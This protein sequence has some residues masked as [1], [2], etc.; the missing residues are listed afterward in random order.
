MIPCAE[1]KTLFLDVGGTLISID[2]DW[3][4][5]EINARG[6]V[7]D[8]DAVCRAEAAA[9][10][11]ISHRLH[12]P[13]RGPESARFYT[14]LQ[15]I[16]ARLQPVVGAGPQ[17]VEALA[18]ELSGVLCP[19][20][21]ANRLWSSVMPG[22][23]EALEA[24]RGRGLQLVAVSN[25]DGSAEQSLQE[26]GLRAYFSVVIDSAR[27][28]F[29]KP[30]PRIFELALRVSGAE[31]SRTLH[32]GDM[33]HADVVGARGAGISALLLDPFDDWVG[34]DCERLPDLDAL[35]RQQGGRKGSD[36][37]CAPVVRFGGSS[38][39]DS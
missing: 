17:C 14:Y 20:G 28:G 7:C 35:V 9:K 16:F 22:V 18:R 27:V 21:Q 23:P 8:T 38:E 10:P 4:A 34:V 33:Y 24:F 37:T 1:L 15:A 36:R 26:T 29:A 25:S 6:F 11:E 31:R 3:V 13:E 32:V 5:A 19:P 30:D 12:S 2:Y 39:P